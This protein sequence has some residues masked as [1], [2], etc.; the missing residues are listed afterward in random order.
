[1]LAWIEGCDSGSSLPGCNTSADCSE[2]QICRYTQCIPG[3]TSDVDC[4]G[5]T[6]EIS[7]GLCNW[8]QASRVSSGS[9]G[10]LTSP[11]L[12]AAGSGGAV[13]NSGTAGALG[14][15]V[16]SAGTS[17]S[18]SEASGGSPPE[19][20]GGDSNG[21][22][23]EPPASETRFE[24][25]DNLED[26]DA[27]ILAENQ[28]TGPW[29]IFNDQGNGGNQQPSGSFMPEAGGA[30]G[31]Q[32]AVHTSGEGFGFAGV[33]FDLNNAESQPEHANSKVFDASAWDGIVFWAKGSAALRVE[34]PTKGFVPPERGGSCSSD[35]WNVYGLHLP[36]ELGE[37]WKE[38]KIPFSE[39]ER[40]DGSTDPA[41]TRNELMSIS[42]RHDGS[43]RFDFWIDEV[44][45]YDDP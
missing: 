7:S 25:I 22:E 8:P 23:D 32:Y 13:G 14:S 6:C 11:P 39:L 24:L 17:G 21:S 5:G 15:E 34:F 3:C 35:C 42:F 19:A 20:S 44:R 31:T 41:F 45:F 27:R 26:N 33:G 2:G 18:A 28:R 38:Y 30:N 1:M 37:E 9:E 10:P 12:S 29:H 36:G 40:G 4:P 16:G 43:K